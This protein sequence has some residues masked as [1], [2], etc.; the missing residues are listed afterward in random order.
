MRK[1][2]LTLLV[3]VLLAVSALL[4]LG[5]TLGDPVRWTPDGLF[6]QARSLEIRG[7]DADAALEHTFQGPLGAE[8]R[9]RDPQR[10][11]D[12]GW[13]R[14]NAQFYERRIALPLAAAALDPVA[15]D[16]A[17][18]DLSA[19]GYVAAVL[20]IFG[21]LLLRFR[22]PIAAAIAFATVF[23]PALMDHSSYPLTDSWGLALETAAIA[24]GL[25]VLDRGPRW[26]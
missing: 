1:A 26:L 12:P 6:Y 13:V 3:A 5:G 18:L 8:L 7:D 24:A 10:S 22:L 14:Y 11:G 17:I 21:L 16:R 19:A 25:L 15:G 20:A 2:G 4:A 9:A 23:L